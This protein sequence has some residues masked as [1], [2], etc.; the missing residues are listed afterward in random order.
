MYCL[1]WKRNNEWELFTNEVWLLEKD[2]INYAKQN[3][4]KK[5]IEWKVDDYKNWFKS[6]A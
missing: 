3:K 1:V 2:A 5:S 4:F 6:N